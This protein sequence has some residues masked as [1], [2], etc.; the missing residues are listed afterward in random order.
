MPKYT[1]LLILFL[2][3]SQAGTLAERLT[4]NLKNMQ[5]ADKIGYNVKS[6]ETF[7]VYREGKYYERFETSPYSGKA[8]FIT[9][10]HLVKLDLYKGIKQG[11]YL[12]FDLEGR[13]IVKTNYLNGKING[14]YEK[15]NPLGE[16]IIDLV[17]KKNQKSG[18][19]IVRFKKEDKKYKFV[20]K[21]GRQ[22]S[23]KEIKQMR[24][25]K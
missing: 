20:F 4:E 25:E 14:K 13:L 11:E 10:K 6:Y 18:Y 5:K 12:K 9:K 21:D 17:Y 16:K 22:I 7:V 1:L 15:W 2:L 3:N 19:E 24:S 8:I 23:K